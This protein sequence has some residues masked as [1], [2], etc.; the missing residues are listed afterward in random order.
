MRLRPEWGLLD[1]LLKRKLLVTG[2]FRFLALDFF[3]VLCLVCTSDTESSLSLRSKNDDGLN[4][5]QWFILIHI[6]T[7]HDL[8]SLQVKRR[9]G[10]K[11]TAGSPSAQPSKIA[12]PSTP[13]LYP[14]PQAHRV[15]SNLYRLSR[16]YSCLTVFTM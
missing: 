7:S 8:L 14:L 4:I 16:Y 2:I 5:A 10:V 15:I 13:I 12:D 6:A 3:M 11:G 9:P 1:E